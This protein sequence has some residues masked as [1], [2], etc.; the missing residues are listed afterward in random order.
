MSQPRPAISRLFDLHRLLV[1][2]Q[3]VDRVVHVPSSKGFRQENDTEHSY[4]LAMMAWF[5]A[6]HFPH[7]DRDKVIRYALAHD[8]VEVHAGDTYVYGDQ[9]MLDSKAEREAAALAQ[10]ETDWPDFPM[11]AETI[12]AYERKAD[13]E[14]KFVYALDKIMPVL[15]IFIGEGRTWQEEGITL[16]MLHHI[17][18]DKVTLSPEIDRYYQEL[19]ALLEEHQHYFAGKKPSQQR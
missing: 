4:N 8:L 1:N 15:L 19:Y 5:L 7:L 18:R 11:L 3:D 6:D 16:E 14:A 2:F 17:K 10:L 9:A 12:H 13:E